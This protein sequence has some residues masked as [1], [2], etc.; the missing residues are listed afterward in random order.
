MSTTITNPI[1]DGRKKS[2]HVVVVDDHRLVRQGI[3]SQINR[4]YRIKI[5]GEACNGI[6]LF[7]LLKNTIVDVI[8][9]DIQMPDMNG[10]QTLKKLRLEYPNIKVLVISMFND[11]RIIREMIRLGA[12][13]FVNKDVKEEDLIDAIYNVNFRGMHAQNEEIRALFSNLFSGEKSESEIDFHDSTRLK[14]RDISILQSICDGYT[15]EEIAAQVKL[16]KQSIDLYRMKLITHFKARN[17][18]HLVTEAIRHGYY[19]P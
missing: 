7:Q 1:P 6:E 18:A 12:N 11:K 17:M 8:L 13:G 3:I 19:I 16:S 14:E 10:P 2:I 4:G 9:L 15:S 5:V